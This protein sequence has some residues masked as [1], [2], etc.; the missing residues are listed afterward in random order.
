MC[1]ARNAAR[2]CKIYRR[3]RRCGIVRRCISSVDIEMKMARRLFER[4]GGEER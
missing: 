3:G 2:K 1:E 4:D